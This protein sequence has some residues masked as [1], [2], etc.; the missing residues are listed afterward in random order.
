MKTHAVR[1]FDDFTIIAANIVVISI[2]FRT[3]CCHCRCLCIVAVAVFVVAIV[4]ITV[5]VIVFDVDIVI[6]IVIYFV[7]VV[8]FN[9]RTRHNP[10]FTIINTA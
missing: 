3:C 4:A 1:R 2:V 8:F 7:V 6:Y 10:S 9:S 5:V